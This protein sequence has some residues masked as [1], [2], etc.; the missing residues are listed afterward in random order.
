MLFRSVT[1]L[2]PK[3]SDKSQL[4]WYESRPIKVPTELVGLDDGSSR[5]RVVALAVL[6]VDDAGAT[7][8]GQVGTNPTT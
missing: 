3:D 5:E 6:T 8:M 7:R 4:I 1:L 2:F